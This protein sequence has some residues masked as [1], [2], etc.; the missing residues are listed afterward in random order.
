MA[1]STTDLMLLATVSFLAGSILP[2]GSEPLLLFQAHQQTNIYSLIIIWLIATFANTIGAIS[3]F[4]GSIW[5]RKTYMQKKQQC[6]NK[7]NSSSK[8]KSSI[9][10][11]KIWLEQKDHP[12]ILFLSFVPFIGD[13]LVIYAT[14]RPWKYIICFLWILLGKAIRYALLLQIFFGL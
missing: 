4:L 5:L 10:S 12:S 9:S 2:I 1:L 11:I 7:Y 13:G 3:L 6:S 8:A 14:F